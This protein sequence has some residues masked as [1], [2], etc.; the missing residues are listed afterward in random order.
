MTIAVMCVMDDDRQSPLR[1]RFDEVATVGTVAT[2]RQ[3]SGARDATHAPIF[4][5]AGSSCGRARSVPSRGSVVVLFRF[6]E[7][8][9]E[10]T[11]RRGSSR[12]P[13]SGAVE[14]RQATSVV[15]TP[16]GSRLR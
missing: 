7:R 2:A 5:A 8:T 13:S 3:R 11:G 4:R 1:S 9:A 14:E 10:A 16:R 12:Q 15:A 6:F